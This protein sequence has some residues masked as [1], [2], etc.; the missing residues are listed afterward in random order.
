MFNAGLARHICHMVKVNFGIRIIK[1]D[2]WRQNA[3]VYG[4]G[5]GYQLGKPSRAHQVACRALGGTDR[6]RFGAIAEDL[7][8][9]SRFRQIPKLG[10]C[11]VGIDV[12]NFARLQ[13]CPLKGNAHAARGA[14]PCGIRRGNMVGVQG[15]AKTR[16]NGK[17]PRAAFL[18]MAFLFDNKRSPAFAND[19]MCIR[20]A[21]DKAVPVPVKGAGSLGGTFIAA[22]QGPR[23]GQG[24]YHAGA[25]DGFPPHGDDGLRLAGHDQKG[26][27]HQRIAAGRAGCVNR[28]GGALDAVGNGQVR[29]R[30]VADDHWHKMRADPGAPVLQQAFFGCAHFRNA[31]HGR[32]H[33]NPCSIWLF[34]QVEPALGNG[35]AA[36]HKSVLHEFGRIA[37]HLPGQGIR[38]LK[39]PDFGGNFAGQG[40]GIEAAYGIYAALTGKQVAPVFLHPY[41][42]RGDRAHSGYYKP[43]LHL[44]FPATLT[45]SARARMVL[46]YTCE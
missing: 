38:W 35:F 24:R 45:R 29:G 17:D 6:G 46:A 40:R 36:G 20:D 26:R 42:N 9:R 34:F 8:K 1:I 12:A 16:K 11:A 2:C 32:A 19:K 37:R 22:R 33:A 30:H 21:N 25:N 13:A 14:G 4:H 27:A 44:A 43:F 23:L 10:R 18:G 5:A 39:I 7:L 15:V 28:K 31:A 41:A 3:L